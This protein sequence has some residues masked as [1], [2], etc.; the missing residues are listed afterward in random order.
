MSTIAELKTLPIPE[1]LQLVEDLW[2]SI[3]LDKTALPDHPH[4]IEEIRLRRM[5]FDANPD[6][7]WTWEQLK[8][9][10]RSGHA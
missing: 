8:R 9:K 5:R 10:I 4:V 7:G 3:A 2:D 1:R 6:S